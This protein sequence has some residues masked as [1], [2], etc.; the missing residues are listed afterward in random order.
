MAFLPRIT[1]IRFGIWLLVGLAFYW[2]YGWTHSRL[3]KRAEES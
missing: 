3:R 1:W 2:L